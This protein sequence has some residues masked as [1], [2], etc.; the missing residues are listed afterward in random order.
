MIN[1]IVVGVDGSDASRNAMAWASDVCA[2]TGA[3]LAMVH[4]VQPPSAEVDPERIARL[5]ASA[6][7][8][9]D[10]AWAGPARARG[11]QVERRVVDASPRQALVAEA[12]DHHPDLV[13]VGRGGT[14]PGSV[15]SDLAHE[16][17][18]PLVLVG[19]YE[20]DTGRPVVVGDDGSDAVGAA[21]QLA[22]E[23]ADAL[24]SRLVPVHASSGE[25]EV[26]ADGAGEGS[27]SD[28]DGPGARRPSVIVDRPA[29]EGL[30]E[31]A[32]E[33]G[34]ACLVVGTRSH[35]LLADLRL[36]RVASRLIDDARVPLVIV[37]HDR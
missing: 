28:A 37:T 11:V 21:E 12:R 9:L 27:R 3:R 5:R 17:T 31:V 1:N 33:T 13:V 35:G 26:P 36:G 22:A 16:L 29:A 20:S 19:A 7:D 15:A 4:A 34:A 23:L 24:G 2:G 32:D 18:V 30:D 14:G 8:Q 10:G 25:D 6:R